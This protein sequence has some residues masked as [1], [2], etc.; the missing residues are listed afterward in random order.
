MNASKK[1]EILKFMGNSENRMLI[2]WLFTIITYVFLF[3]LFKN[4]FVLLFG[5]FA[6]YLI[7]SK[8]YN[9]IYNKIKISFKNPY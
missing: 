8:L 7:Y 2:I 6:S 1:E 5:Y 3:F 9:Y 4:T